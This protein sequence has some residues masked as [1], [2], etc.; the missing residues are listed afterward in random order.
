MHS[1]VLVA[2]GFPRGV[3]ARGGS[4]RHL[5]TVAAVRCGDQYGINVV[6]VGQ[7]VER[8]RM[9]DAV[10]A[11]QARRRCSTGQAASAASGSA[12]Q[13]IFTTPAHKRSASTLA[14]TAY[15]TSTGTLASEAPQ[16]LADSLRFVINADLTEVEREQILGGN[17][18]RLL[19]LS[20]SRCA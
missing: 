3:L 14:G 8:W 19:D 17:G 12:S 9:R 18:V 20:V 10:A 2:I 13:R 7:V 11:G 16:T 5:L 1:A 6:A 15:T 4:A